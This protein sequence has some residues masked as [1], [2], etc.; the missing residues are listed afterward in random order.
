VFDPLLAWAAEDLGWHMRATDSILG[1][2]QDDA[3]LV[4]VRS[5]LEGVQ[6]LQAKPTHSSTLMQPPLQPPRSEW[7]VLCLPAPHCCPQ[8]HA[9]VAAAP[10]P[11]WTSTWRLVPADAAPGALTGLNSWQLAAVEQLTSAAKSLVVAAALAR[12]R[13]SV[14]AAIQAARL[15][16]DFQLEDWGMVEAGHD[17]DIVDTRTRVAAPMAL[18]RL[19]GDAGGP[20]PPRQQQE[21]PRE[22]QR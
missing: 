18:L 1:A 16:E 10:S 3:T 9:A 11:S 8:P 4:A 19:L 7:G 14:E 12:G 20:A 17:L 13:L 21:Q 5:Y 6:Q 2:T 22:A 15:E